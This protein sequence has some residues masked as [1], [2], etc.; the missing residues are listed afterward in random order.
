MF[1]L[2]SSE[3]WIT[4]RDKLLHLLLDLP[5]HLL[6]LP[7]LLVGLG[8]RLGVGLRLLGRGKLTKFAEFVSANRSL[9]NRNNSPR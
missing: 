5:L 7:P 9:S 4:H 1:M 8:L 6:G 2:K 3:R